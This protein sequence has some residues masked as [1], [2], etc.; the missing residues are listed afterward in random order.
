M[1]CA[2]SDHGDFGRFFKDVSRRRFLR[3]AT[4]GG[5][6]L[7]LPSGQGKEDPGAMPGDDSF[8][9][10]SR[11]LLRDWCDG[12]LALQIHDPA[13]PA[14]HGALGCP[15]CGFIHGRCMDAVYPFFHMAKVT[16]QARY[17]DAGIA[18]FEWSKNVSQD[19]GSWTVIS[20]PTSWRG[21]TVFGAIALADTL[22]LHGE[23]LD[24]Q[25][26]QRWRE[27][28]GRAGDYIYQNFVAL[29]F[30]N[31]NYGCT[32]IYAMD[33]LGRSLDR[34]T[35]LARSRELASGLKDFLT[36]PN[37]LL[38]GEG[39]PASSI[40]PRGCRAVDL[41]Y[42]VEESLV[43]LALCADSA[44]DPELA[45]L[46][47]RSLEAHLAFMLPDGGWDNSWGTRQSKWSYW[48]SRTCDGCQPGYAV[49]AKHHPAFA[50][51]VI[52]NTRLY[53]TCTDSGLLH[54][55]PHYVS[56]GVK[57]C[58]HHTF[59]HAK[60]LATLRDHGDLAKQIRATA[61]LPR[62]V[63]DGIREYPEIATW[64]AARGPWRATVTAYD[65]IYHQRAQQP[66]GGALSMLWHAEVGP[67]LAGSMARYHLVEKNNMQLHPD[68]DDHPLT[69]RIEL[70]QDDTWFTQL[71]DLTAKVVSSDINGVIGFE[72][73]GRLCSDARHE[74]KQGKSVFS[75][76]YQFDAGT[77][78]IVA[79][80]PGVGSS[81]ALP[82]LV[83]PLIS[84]SGEKVDQSV[85]GRIEIHKPKGKVVIEA[86][87]P[88]R[89]Q[90]TKRTRIFNLVPGFEA[91]PII[92][93][94][95]TNARL[96]CRIRV[97][98]W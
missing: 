87:V 13:D 78:T 71:Y 85:P 55:G 54:G 80:A 48:G 41:G 38:F 81:N 2:N 83:I 3:A 28:L 79:Q 42:N 73:S 53:R 11:E 20:D 82:R 39:K 52:E 15:S 33:L 86:N 24:P 32:G 88:L 63:A 59:T 14:R 16:G 65:W 9:T 7:A 77:A 45:A 51:A 90:Q 64:L 1:S 56:H 46:V 29:D 43:A 94:I 96:E 84:P 98:S 25:T 97:I 67:L 40:S 70:W 44:G 57:P 74:P 26:R 76:S 61:P 37:G 95:P 19:D 75:L 30:S 36:R 18:V 89:I 34:P 91:V 5:V 49:F 22:Q 62:A 58:V 17:L 92:A 69:P 72:V 31:I 10:L 4:L 66:T 6:A 23:L 60:A 50:T 21:I 27:R 93:D 12:M 47:G 35:Y 68:A 8:D